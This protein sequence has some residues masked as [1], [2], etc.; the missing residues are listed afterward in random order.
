MKFENVCIIL[1]KCTEDDQEKD[2]IEFYNEA[3]A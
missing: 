1:N 3:K 2:V